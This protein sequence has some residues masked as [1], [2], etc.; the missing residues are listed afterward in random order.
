VNSVAPLRDMGGL[1]LPVIFR[2]SLTPLKEKMHLVG[3]PS[4]I[5][6]PAGGGFALGFR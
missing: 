4:G 1:D 2:E 6:A 5:A 3:K